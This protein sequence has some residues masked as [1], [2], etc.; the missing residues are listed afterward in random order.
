MRKIILSVGSGVV[1]F[2]VSML[3]SFLL[4]P[5]ILRHLTREEYAFFYMLN[6]IVVWLGILRG[7]QNGGFRYQL[8]FGVHRKKYIDSLFSTL[9]IFYVI[10]SCILLAL[11]LLVY[12]L[13]VQ[14]VDTAGIENHSMGFVYGLLLFN[15][16]L[17][18]ISFL[19]SNL[20]AVYNKEYIV[21][22]LRLLLLVIQTVLTWILLRNDFNVLA[23]VIPVSLTSILFLMTTLYFVRSFNYQPLFHV[24][25]FSH[26]VLFNSFN[27]G[28]WF[29]LGFLAQL[30]IKH[31]DVLCIGKMEGLTVLTSF[32]LTSKLYLVAMGG[33][34]IVIKTLNPHFIKLYRRGAENHAT[35]ALVYVKLLLGALFAIGMC[36]Y[37]F[38]QKFMSL[39][40]GQDYYLGDTV[41]L[42]LFISYS[43]SMFIAIIRSIIL[44]KEDLRTIKLQDL[45]EGV[46]N[47]SLSILLGYFWGVRGIVLATGI[48]S[49][50]VLW[51]YFIPKLK[52][53]IGSSY[54]PYFKQELLK[55][56]FLLLIVLIGMASPF[57]VK[58]IVQLLMILLGV[59]CTCV[60]FIYRDLIQVLKKS[61]TH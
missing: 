61:T 54:E 5:Y 15:F 11:G 12:P 24:R 52:A 8:S 31:T 44:S 36:I 32:L 35:W 25:Q 23:L 59:V 29:L 16:S 10:L 46:L 6:S 55:F 57:F 20:L 18:S 2:G 14:W 42:I 51:T 1:F 7:G 53:L 22:L 41:N 21:Y 50:I 9:L 28:R 34:L 47:F 58:E 13:F 17:S 27:V 40:V 33:F 19:F 56:L 38:N 43:L 39:W 37:I 3:I 4:T 48:A 26:K 45:K 49:L 30:F 60:F